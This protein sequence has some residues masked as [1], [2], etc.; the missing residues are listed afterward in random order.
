ML[1][2]YPGDDTP[3]CTRQLNAY[4]DDIAEFR[5]RRR[6]GAGHQPAVGREPRRASAP[7]RAA[8]P[9]RCWPTPTRR[10]AGLRHPRAARLLPAVG[11]RR[12]RRR[13]S[14]ATPTG[15]WPGSRS[16]P[17]TSW[18]PR[19][20]A[21]SAARL[22][23]RGSTAR[24]AAAARVEPVF[25]LG[26]DPGLSRCGYG[27]VER[28][29]RTHAGRGRRR[30]AHRPGR[31]VPDRLAALQ[32]D[33][34]A[35]SPSTGRRW[36]PSSGCCS[37]STCAR[38][39][40]SPRRPA[41]PWP[42]RVTAGCE[43][44]EYSPNQVKQAVTGHGAADKAPGRAH[45]ADAARHRHAAAPGRRRRRGG[46]GPVPPGRTPRLRTTAGEGGA[47][48]DRL[49]ARRRCSTGGAGEVLVEVGG[50]GYRSWW[51]PPRPS[52]LGAIGDEVFV[53]IAP[54]RPRR[55]RHALRL[56]HPRR[57]DD[58][59]G[60]DRRP[61]RRPRHWRWRSC[62]C[63]ARGRWRASSPTTT[64]PPCAWSPAWGRRRRPGC[65]SS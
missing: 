42:R 45:G 44:V 27:V 35:L 61:R 54:P 25:V 1:V 30:A 32:A 3:V 21:A 41:W 13:A 33:V 15:R 16:G 58:V 59:R 64:W 60:A 14:S 53:W 50:V 23:R 37:R 39:S 62:P 55:R 10:W 19:R 46:P 2:F 18:S 63:T 24:A 40:R 22:S 12:R 7:T 26:I 57:A 31:P 11:V 52:P 5:E 43:V 38:P 36:S 29:G 34:R 17:P 65:W 6:P 56:R 20:S 4:T 28:V 9:S 8:S 47:A 49:A 51:R 48:G